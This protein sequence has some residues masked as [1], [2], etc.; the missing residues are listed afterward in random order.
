MGKKNKNQKQT[1]KPTSAC[2]YKRTLHTKLDWKSAGVLK[3]VSVW[4]ENVTL[5][6]IQTPDSWE[7]F[8]QT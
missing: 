2:K 5:P 3:Y 1:K 7:G 4:T 6:S 8:G